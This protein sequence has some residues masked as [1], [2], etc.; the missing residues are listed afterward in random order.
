MAGRLLLPAGGP[1]RKD[2]Y[3]SDHDQDE[4]PENKQMSEWEPHQPPGEHE[5]KAEPPVPHEDHHAKNNQND[6]DRRIFIF[7]VSHMGCWV[8]NLL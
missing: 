6:R 8:K 1:A 7:N 2:K 4:G 3:Q 5:M